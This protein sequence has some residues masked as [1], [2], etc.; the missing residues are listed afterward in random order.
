MKR[1]IENIIYKDSIE[2]HYLDV[3]NYVCDRLVQNGKIREY[4]NEIEYDPYY[5][6]LNVKTSVIFNKS[7]DY[8]TVTLTP[9]MLQGNIEDV[10]E[11]L[12]K[13]IEQEYGN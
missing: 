7:L 10:I 1:L 6:T 13:D 12:N 9:E 2:N 4:V 5:E 11:N 8:I 3:M